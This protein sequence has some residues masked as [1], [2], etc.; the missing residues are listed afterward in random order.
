[1]LK[2]H[3]CGVSGRHTALLRRSSTS[4]VPLVLTAF[5]AGHFG[6]GGSKTRLLCKAEQWEGMR[7]TVACS[8]DMEVHDSSITTRKAEPTSSSPEF[9]QVG[10]DG[11]CSARSQQLQWLTQQERAIRAADE[12][13]D[14][15]A[16]GSVKDAITRY[17]KSTRGGLRRDNSASLANIASTLSRGA[18]VHV[19]SSP[20]ELRSQLAKAAANL[21]FLTRLR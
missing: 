17:K 12:A 11:V 18:P 6:Y 5:P 19:L 9:K 20:I 15:A 1:M 21:G 8:V 13:V 2:E 3:S 10:G 14:E 16:I 4:I 7:L